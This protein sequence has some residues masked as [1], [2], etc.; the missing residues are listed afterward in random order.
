[1]FKFEEERRQ[2]VQLNSPLPVASK[3]V[4]SNPHPRAEIEMEVKPEEEN[5]VVVPPSLRN[6]PVEKENPNK[7]TVPDPGETHL[8]DTSQP[9]D[10][11]SDKVETYS[12]KNVIVF[13]GNVVA[14]QKDIVI[15]ADSIEAFMMRDGKGIERVI[16]SGNVR[17]Q[18]GLRVANCQKAVFDN[19]D[20]KVILTGDPRVREGENIVSGDE[21]VFDIAQNRVEV[22]G[23]VGGRGKVKIRP[24]G[25]FEKTK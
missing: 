15:Y 20:Q 7:G 24:G 6:R 14:R 13:K 11:T 10:I 2:S 23:G 8:V 22:K 3:P 18:Q 16:A 17:V 12:K 21:I 19:L 25:E 9:I 5:R 4:K 1:L